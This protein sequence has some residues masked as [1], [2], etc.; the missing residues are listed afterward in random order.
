MKAKRELEHNQYK[1]YCL[2]Y[3]GNGEYDE[4]WS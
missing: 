1:A 3:E 2:E 4:A